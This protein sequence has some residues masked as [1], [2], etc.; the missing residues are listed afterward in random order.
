MSQSAGPFTDRYGLVFGYDMS[1]NVNCYKGE[2]TTNIAYA[3]NNYL[4]SG[5]NW[6]V[7]GGSTDFND[8]DTSIPKPIIPNVDTSNLRIF[9]STVTGGGSNQQ[10][11]SSI[12]SISPSTQYTMSIYFWFQGSTLQIP[13]YVRTAVNNDSLGYFEYNGSTNYLNWPR[14]KWIRLSKTFTTQANETGV[15]MS[16]YTGDYVGEK[17][18]YFGYQLEQKDHMTPLVLGTR[19]INTGLYNLSDNTPITL[20]TLSY[21][22][23]ANFSFDGS[24]DNMDADV[25]LTYGNCSIEMICKWTSSI[26][27]LFAAGTGS[28]GDGLSGGTYLMAR[29]TS[30]KFWI[31]MYSPQILGGGW[32]NLDGS[33]HAVATSLSTNTYYHITLVNNQSTWSFY[34]NGSLAGSSNH[35]YVSNTGATRLGIFRN[36]VQNVGNAGEVKMFKVYNNQALNST[37]VSINYNNYK[38]RYNI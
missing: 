15:Y 29:A 38:K 12:I 11:G 2:P 35:N 18:A 5:S 4:N 28:M 22:S 6:W 25:Q 8:N 14:G 26:S 34:V 16:S 31:G 33:S 23:S 24:D 7:N 21:D 3:T 19:G 30:S 1:E 13:P 9:S 32:Y 10:L 20:T 17:L 27:D 37:D 36:H